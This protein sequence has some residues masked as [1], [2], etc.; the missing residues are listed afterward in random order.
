MDLTLKYSDY[1]CEPAEFIINDI[2]A[3]IGD[4]G[5]I[6]GRSLGDTCCVWYESGAC[7]EGILKK[8][9]ISEGEFSDICGRIA[10]ETSKFGMCGL[11]E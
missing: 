4:I 5:D 10:V 11:C 8:Y 2:P 6:C 7:Y 3:D 1:Y 9:G